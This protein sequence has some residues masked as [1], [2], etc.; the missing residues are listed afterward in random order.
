MAEPTASLS[1][2]LLI[3]LL[4]TSLKQIIKSVDSFSVA[5]LLEIQ[6]ELDGMTNVI[7]MKIYA[8]E[9]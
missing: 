3:Q 5:Q 8:R 1:P 6:S 4:H 9:G 7:R 2:R